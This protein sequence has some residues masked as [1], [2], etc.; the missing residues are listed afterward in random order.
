MLTHDKHVALTQSKRQRA[1]DAVRERFRLAEAAETAARNRRLEARRVIEDVRRERQRLEDERLRA[2]MLLE[3]ADISLTL[4]DVM[5]LRPCRRISAVRKMLKQY[6]NDDVP[7]T[8][9]MALDAGCKES[10]IRWVQYQLR[11]YAPQDQ[12]V[13]TA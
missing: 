3:A 7:V 13:D 6:W 11:R 10:D 5:A 9:Q 2:K 1:L 4:D 12:N 8:A